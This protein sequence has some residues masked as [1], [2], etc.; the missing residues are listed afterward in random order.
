M[1]GYKQRIENGKLAFGA[2]EKLIARKA[3]AQDRTIYDR[4]SKDLD[5]GFLLERYNPT[6]V[7]AT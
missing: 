3:T 4:Y 6:V 1:R 7:K 2:M 5:F